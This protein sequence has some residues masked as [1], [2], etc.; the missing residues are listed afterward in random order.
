MR[1]SVD[2]TRQE[3]VPTVSWRRYPSNGRKRLSTVMQTIV[4]Y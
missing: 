2:D 3:G 4:T 1:E